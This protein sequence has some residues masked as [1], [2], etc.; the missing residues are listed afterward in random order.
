MRAILQENLIKE[1]MRRQK[2]GTCHLKIV[3]LDMFTSSAEQGSHRE[4]SEAA[5]MLIMQPRD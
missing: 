2:Y 3:I 4:D 5:L 1:I